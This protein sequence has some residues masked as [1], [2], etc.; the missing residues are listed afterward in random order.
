MPEY[1]EYIAPEGRPNHKVFVGKTVILQPE[2]QNWV[3]VST[4]QAGLLQIEPYRKLYET[5]LCSASQAVDPV[6]P[7]NYFN[8]M[9]GNFGD[10]PITLLKGQ[11]VA[12]ADFHPLAITESLISHAEVFGI[13]ENERHTY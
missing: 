4:P 10:K 7:G 8:I 11:R 3:T 5:R 13:E 9:I 12:N 1:Q 6:E 2:S